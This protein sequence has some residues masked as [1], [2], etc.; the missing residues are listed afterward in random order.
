[1]RKALLAVLIVALLA[2]VVTWRMGLQHWL[3]IHTGTL[4]EPG[5]YYGFFS[6]FGSDL[7]ELALLGG[8]VGLL[9][10]YNC[11]VHGCWRLGRH[12]TAAGHAVCRRHHPDDHLTVQDVAAAH[13][14][15]KAARRNPFAPA[16]ERLK[17]KDDQ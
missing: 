8:V 12:T 2:L 13:E 16:M 1:M 6:G 14:A 5:P 3:A 10:K 15:A 11:E 9:R 4:N 17:R 7:S